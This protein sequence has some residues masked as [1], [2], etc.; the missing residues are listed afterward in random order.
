MS[1]ENP[2]KPPELVYPWL[3][4]GEVLWRL[5]VG[6]AALLLGLF[7]LSAVWSDGYTHRQW[8]RAIASGALLVA[9]SPVPLLSALALM[10]NHTR[11]R[12]LPSDLVVQHGPIPFPGARLARSEISAFE[13]VV[14]PLSFGAA[15]PIGSPGSGLPSS[16][17]WSVQAF[18]LGGTYE[19]VVSGIPTREGAMELQSVLRRWLANADGPSA[20]VTEVD[21]FG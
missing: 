19:D 17:G 20:M 9:I 16:R 8:S 3:R 21:P 2:E 5:L 11:V 10:V 7:L 13:V 18:R 12:L 14:S 1:R 4:P 15:F 6:S